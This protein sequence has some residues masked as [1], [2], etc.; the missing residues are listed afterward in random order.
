MVVIF[1]IITFAAFFLVDYLVRR[2]DKTIR[3]TEKTKKSPIFL[4]PEKALLPLNNVEERLYHPSHT[5][6]LHNNTDDFFIGYDQFISFL[7]S[8]DIKIH[9]VHP[10]GKK[11]QQGEKIWE[12]R[13]N[14]HSIS[15]LSPISGEITE[16]NPACG[17]G[18]PL[19]S[20]S[21]EKSWIMQIKAEAVQ[22]ERNNLL[23]HFQANSTIRHLKDEVFSMA[24]NLNYMAD[25]G[26]IDPSFINK[27]EKDEWLEFI[28]KFFPYLTKQKD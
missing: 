13:S 15:Q 22:N 21:V 20:S 24:S 23:N 28:Q 10:V 26:K 4:S 16:I 9:D 2:E 6:A 18:I 12:I 11:I 5:W 14:G 27:M 7:F 25:G 17:V 3:E 19:P 8:S 1:V